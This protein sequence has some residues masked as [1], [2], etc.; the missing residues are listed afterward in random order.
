MSAAAAPGRTR[1]LATAGW[2]HAARGGAL[3]FVVVAALA[4]GAALAVSAFGGPGLSSLGA[5]R[6]GGAYL[7]LVHRVPLRLAAE[8]GDLWVA[9][10]LGAPAGTR[11]LEVRLAV[12]PL[13]LTALAA[14][15]L[16]RAG[17]R[18]AEA[19]GGAPAARALHGAKVAPVYAALV[20]VSTLAA[21][22][23]LEPPALDL[24]LELS[25][26]AVPAFVLPLALAAAA[27]A[28]G[29]WWSARA[30]G[31]VRAAVLGGWVMLLAG[32]G[33][34]L[35]GLF[36]AGVVRPG[37]PEAL[38]LPTSGRYLRAVLARPSVGAVVVAHHLAVLPNEAAWTLVPAMGGCTGGYPGEG[39]PVAFLCY[40]RFPRSLRLPAWLRPP[41]AEAGPPTRFGPAPWP[42]LAFL[43]AP[44]AATVLGGRRA[45]RASERGNALVAAIGAGAVF[46]A[47]VLTLAWASSVQVS[48]TVRTS[49][50]V[51]QARSVRIGPDLAAGTALALGWGVAGGA[52]GAALSGWPGARRGGS[53][54]PG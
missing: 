50:A 51:P 9:S 10:V 43:L 38:L 40:G 18:T 2:G 20:L 26:P 11:A 46:A 6:V 52:L 31:A 48:T 49:G 27:G 8:G 15:L 19:A 39:E 21:R 24:R 47:L 12:A 34:C 28:A 33:L 32:L 44:A 7:A 13:A 45:A 42:Y 23:A 1:A 53:R 29:G 3:A 36:A 37:G 54:R 25:V 17:R 14:W 22:V 30:G 16:W 41:G 4:G 5:L 35:A